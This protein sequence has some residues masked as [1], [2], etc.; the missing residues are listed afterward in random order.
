M[1]LPDATRA[2]P[3]TLP[4]GTG[5]KG[6]V[7]LNQVVSHPRMRVGDFSYASDFDP[8][9]EWAM[10]LAPYLFPFSQE[11]LTIGKFCQIAHGVRFIT[12]SANHETKG[13]STFPFAVFAPETRVGYQPD[14]RDMTI[15]NDVWIGYGAL[16]L[17]GAHVGNGVI[18]GAGSVVRGTVPD[19]AVVSGNPA[20]VVRMRYTDDEISDLNALEWW[21]WPL[22]RIA[23]AQAALNGGSVDDLKVFAPQ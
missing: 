18:V 20:R 3:I 12:S 13:P 10:H 6:T 15:G 14:T 11:L 4:D 19:Y 1:S 16:I 21:N 23:L 7:F 8:P 9:A 22:D 2:Y 17:P 5:H